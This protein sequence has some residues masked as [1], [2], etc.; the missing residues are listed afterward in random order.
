MP[1][2]PN[3]KVDKNML[4]A[5]QRVR[6]YWLTLISGAASVIALVLHLLAIANFSLIGP[7][8]GSVAGS[9]MVAGIRGYTDS[10]Y[11]QLVAVGMRWTMVTLGALVLVLRANGETSLVARLLP[12][13]NAL[14]ADAYMLV[15]ILGVAFHAGYAFAYLRDIATEAPEQ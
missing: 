14:D 9:L 2:D 11:Q 15:L 6:V 13:V 3:P 7:L 1:Y 8:I 12:G 4:V 10:Y 5:Q